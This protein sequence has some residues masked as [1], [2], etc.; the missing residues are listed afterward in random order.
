VSSPSVRQLGAAADDLRD[1][2]ARAALAVPGVAKLEPTLQNALRRLQARTTVLRDGRGV[3]SAADGIELR[4]REDV[5][6]VHVDIVTERGRSAAEV[7]RDVRHTLQDVLVQH[8][9]QPGALTVAVLSIDHQDV[10]G[11]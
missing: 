9:L 7:A 6:D 10:P 5:V 4:R 1:E 8:G 11:R 3:R 2:L